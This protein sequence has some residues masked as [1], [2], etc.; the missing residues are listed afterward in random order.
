MKT[1]TDLKNNL[2]KR[3]E[4]KLIVDSSGNPGFA[5]ALN[6]VAQQ[7][8]APEENIVVKNVKGKFGRDTFLIDAFVYDSVKDKESIEPRVKVKKNADGTVAK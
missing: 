1:Q 4:I 8:K 6:M 5:S 3:R 7:I 2:L